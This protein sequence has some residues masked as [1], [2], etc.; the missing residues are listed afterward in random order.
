MPDSYFELRISAARGSDSISADMMRHLYTR[1]HLGKALVVCDQPIVMLSACRK[2]WLK[3]SRV[4][5]RQRASTLNADKILKY[6]HT[7]AHMQRMH[8]TAQEPLRF[9][10]GDV[11][12]LSPQQLHT[13]P[14]ACYTTYV[15]ADL[16][17]KTAHK[18]ASATPQYSLVVDYHHRLNW[19]EYGFEPKKSLEKQVSQHWEEVMAFLKTYDVDPA[20][21]YNGVVRDISAMDDALD[22]LLGVS[23]KFMVVANEFQRT[24]ELARPIRLS[25]DI[26][27]RYDA[28]N[29]L[30]HRIQAL[31]T[32]SYSQRFLE[33]YNEDDT[34]FLYDSQRQ[35]LLV[36]FEALVMQ[37]RRAG[38]HNL[39]EALRK[40]YMGRSLNPVRNPM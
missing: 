2:Q 11:F 38:R 31:S 33:L 28:F 25:K 37:H 1:Q 30:A 6:T 29:L 40:F 8:F 22:T 10:E 39:A 15:M 35:P 21:L 3:L 9:P 32:E 26:R 13:L 34:F 19:A 4:I 23:Q 36:P 24:L 5:Q 17:D 7:I 16:P 20:H 12:F 18:L 14:L 27:V